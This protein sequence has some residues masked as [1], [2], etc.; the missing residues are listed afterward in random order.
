MG[1]VTSKELCQVVWGI[2][3]K[4]FMHKY[5]FIVNETDAKLRKKKKNAYTNVWYNCQWRHFRYAADEWLT[6]APVYQFP[7]V[8]CGRI[9][10]MPRTRHSAIKA[11]TTPT[12]R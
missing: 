9:Q 4:N 12:C 8:G 1:L 7:I 5:S 6:A 2:V 3:I 11:L 10:S